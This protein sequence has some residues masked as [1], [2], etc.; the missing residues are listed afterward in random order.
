MLWLAILPWT[1][2]TFYLFLHIPLTS[3]VLRVT[4]IRA[5]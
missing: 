2:S 4:H 1:L 5:T 3:S